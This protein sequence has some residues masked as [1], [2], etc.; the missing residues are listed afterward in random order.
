MQLIFAEILLYTNA[1]METILL[2]IWMRK[3]SPGSKPYGK[4]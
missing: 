4:T 3:V 2:L 1:W